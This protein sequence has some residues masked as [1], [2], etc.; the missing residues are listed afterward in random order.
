[1]FL[2]GELGT[3][4]DLFEELSDTEGIEDTGDRDIIEEEEVEP[5]EARTL[6]GLDKVSEKDIHI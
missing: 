6:G 1:M 4:W 2:Y 5:L 3:F